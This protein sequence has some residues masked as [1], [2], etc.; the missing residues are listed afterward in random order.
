MKLY[1]DRYLIESNAFLGDN[2]PRPSNALKAVIYFDM[3]EYV[4]H[5]PVKY[6]LY[7]WKNGDN[8]KKKSNDRPSSY[9]TPDIYPEDIFNFI[10]IRAG[11]TLENR[12]AEN[13]K[14][15]QIYGLRGP[16]DF[17]IKEFVPPIVGGTYCE[18]PQFQTVEETSIIAYN[19][20]VDF[21][22]NIATK[23]SLLNFIGGNTKFVNHPLG[24][25]HSLLVENLYP[26]NNY[27]LLILLRD[28]KGN[29]QI[30]VQNFIT[31]QRKVNIKLTKLT[32]EYV[33]DGDG[34]GESSFFIGEVILCDI[35]TIYKQVFL[36][37]WWRSNHVAGDTLSIPGYCQTQ[38][39]Y[40]KYTKD[41]HVLLK[42]FG[43]E[44]NGLDLAGP[45]RA[46][47]EYVEGFLVP[48]TILNPV[49]NGVLTPHFSK[50]KN[51]NQPVTWAVKAQSEEGHGSLFV[52]HLA[53]EIK[54][55]YL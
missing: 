11:E 14:E 23:F 53:C 19:F 30:L 13:S 47:S 36:P 52:F 46:N 32:T 24:N 33:G 8:P 27:T 9:L 43:R 37:F 15:I 38:F 44:G 55:E 12:T 41:T 39:P 29:W 5:I 10:L 6:D 2:V 31:K 7:F 1:A 50:G 42:T 35:F 16:I 4:N 48:S 25:R 45:G 22:W 49:S 3:E 18:F 40:Q 17:G 34:V 54:C 20:L 51:E 21:Q 26:G 28:H